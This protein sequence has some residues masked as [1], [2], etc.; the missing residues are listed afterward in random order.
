MKFS[1]KQKGGSDQSKIVSM[2]EDRFK[3]RVL[4]SEASSYFG[5]LM[6]IVSTERSMLRF[7]RDRGYNT[8]EICEDRN[9]QHW[10]DDTT[11]SFS[12]QMRT[13]DFYKYVERVLTLKNL[14]K[15]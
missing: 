3:V 15:S 13:G 5:N 9:L 14:Q 8:C 11:I 12:D 2:L 4:Q 6:L 7:V 1:K 10:M